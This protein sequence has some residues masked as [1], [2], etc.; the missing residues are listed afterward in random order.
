[1]WAVS[2]IMGLFFLLLS[3][4]SLF[5]LLQ[6]YF[7]Q[8]G[9]QR[10]AEAKFMNQVYLLVMG[11]VVLIA[12]IIVEEYFKVGVQKGKLLK[13]VA[14]IMGIEILLIFAAHVASSVLMGF[15]FLV[16]LVLVLELGVGVGLTWFGVKSK[17][18]LVTLP[19]NSQSK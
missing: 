8:G 13:R 2:I 17:G 18:V 9:Y 10:G 3:R 7:V 19:K 1:M 4:D 16:V 11:F 5:G 6:V 14:K 12:M 15:S